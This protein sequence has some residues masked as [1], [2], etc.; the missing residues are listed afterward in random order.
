[1]A[2]YCSIYGTLVLY[3]TRYVTVTRPSIRSPCSCCAL[4]WRQARQTRLFEYSGFASYRTRECPREMEAAIHR[5]IGLGSSVVNAALK[6]VLDIRNYT[7]TCSTLTTSG[8]FLK[9]QVFRVP[10]FI[11]CNLMLN[12]TACFLLVYVE[13]IFARAPEI[14]RIKR[15]LDFRR[16]CA[17][18]LVFLNA[19]VKRRNQ[20]R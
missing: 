14:R 13:H 2:L 4:C 6:S 5:R 3:V 16:L 8:P 15:S 9:R 12:A 18:M 1:M 17:K 20:S 19:R 11:R 10:L 7:Y